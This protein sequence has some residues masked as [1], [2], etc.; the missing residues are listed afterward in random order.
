LQYRRLLVVLLCTN[1]EGRVDA[2]ALGGRKL[3]LASALGTGGR[4]LV[5]TALLAVRG[6]FLL[7][8]GQQSGETAHLAATAHPKTTMCVKSVLGGGN[9]MVRHSYRECN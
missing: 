1:G 6:V 3:P 9:K 7:W 2:D 8:D 4:P 5:R